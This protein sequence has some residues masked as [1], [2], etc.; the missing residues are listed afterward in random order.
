MVSKKQKKAQEGINSR[1]ALVMKSGKAR[2]GYKTTLKS[3][4]LGQAKL[5]GLDAGFVVDIDHLRPT[6]PLDSASDSNWS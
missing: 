1:L 6:L 4:R 5:I 2:I 3:L